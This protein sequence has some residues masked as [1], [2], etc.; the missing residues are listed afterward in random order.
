MVGLVSK[1]KWA[2]TRG[3]VRELAKILKDASKK[4]QEGPAL[5]E[6]VQSPGGQWAY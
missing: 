3:L 5:F 6:A 2:K 4:R 1:G